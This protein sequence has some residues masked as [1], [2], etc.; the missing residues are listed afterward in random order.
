MNIDSNLDFK[1]TITFFYSLIEQKK[2][3]QLSSLKKGIWLY[4]FLLIFEGALRKWFLPGLAT[5]LLIVRDPLAV[6]ML[7]KAWEKGLFKLNFYILIMWICAGVAFVIA[8][9]FGHRNL[10][11]AIFGV[12]ILLFHFPLMFVIGKV[13]SRDDVI[14]MGKIC[15]YIAIPMLI[16]IG[17]QF[18]SPQAA[19]VNRGVGGDLSGAGFSGAMGYFRPPGTFS[20]TNGNSMFW[21][22]LAPFV[23]FFWLNSKRINRF[24]LLM[25]ATA[26]LVSIPLSISRSLL[27]G[28]LLSIGFAFFII[29]RKPEYFKQALLVIFGLFLLILVLQYIPVFQK[30]V[31]VFTDRFTSANENEGGVKG[32]LLDRFLGGMLGA[33][34]NSGELP[35]S[36]YG[37]GMGT[38]VGSM[39]LTG[40]RTFLISEGEWG[41]LIGEMGIILG[42]FVI[43]TRLFFVLKLT[44][45]SFAE[46]NRGNGLPWLLLSFGFI[47]ILQG[48]WAQPTALG[49]STLI[50]GLILASLK[51][52]PKLIRN[53][54][55]K[56]VGK[57]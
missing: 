45:A 3:A 41:R 23:I 44:I 33:I 38:N 30:G 31:E 52:K 40:D 51:H 12:R 4:F 39:L 28:V 46:L 17:L 25:A 16:L 14:K 22:L 48:Q 15:L 56:R 20:F 36:G 19:W 29:V 55:S 7:L 9:L 43:L 27:F 32:V 24:V 35:V 2:S 34:A 53:R 50:G 5:P 10:F 18:L 57:I 47:I 26:L 21:G 37:I 42:M 11:V 8:M 49:F 6:W 13:F 1:N 54:I